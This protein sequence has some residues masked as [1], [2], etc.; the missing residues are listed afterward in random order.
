MYRLCK[1]TECETE[2]SEVNGMCF[3]C[4]ED[5]AYMIYTAVLESSAGDVAAAK[6]AAHKVWQ[7][8]A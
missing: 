3:S 4:A 5:M 6:A 2:A 8:S 7:V 1:V